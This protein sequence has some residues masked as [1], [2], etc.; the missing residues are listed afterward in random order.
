[1]VAVNTH[2]FHADPDAP[3]RMRNRPHSPGRNH[4]QTAQ[5]P[6]HD[7]DCVMVDQADLAQAKF[8]VGE[9]E[10]ASLARVRKSSPMHSEAGGTIDL[11]QQP[12]I[13]LAES[14]H[15]PADTLIVVD[16]IC[17]SE[18]RVHGQFVGDQTP[19]APAVEQFAQ[20]EIE[21]QSVLCFLEA[22]F[23][24]AKHAQPL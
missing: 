18:T 8:A 4:A 5:P 16:C 24:F 12:E 17:R 3:P 9:F 20:T 7:A 23:I 6:T 13:D 19:G 2:P 15:A 14:L 11:T 21:A 22:S 1:M 10:P